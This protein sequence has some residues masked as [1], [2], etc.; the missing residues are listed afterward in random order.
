MSEQ[1][2]KSGEYD[3][4]FHLPEWTGVLADVS[5]WFVNQLN[6]IPGVT[7]IRA[8]TVWR[9][10]ERVTGYIWSQWNPLGPAPTDV[11]AE[12][13]IDLIIRFGVASPVSLAGIIVVIGLAIVALGLIAYIC[14]TV[15]PVAVGMGLFLLIL[16]VL[17]MMG[18]RAPE[19]REEARLR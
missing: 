7:F 1:E 11:I 15:G 4:T 6:V 14:V 19:R 17:M 18:V 12:R 5:A 3:I 8:W 9:E 16:V 10:R 2:L 13:H